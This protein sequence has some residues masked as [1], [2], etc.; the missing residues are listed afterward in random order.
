MYNLKDVANFSS[1]YTTRLYE[2]LQEFKETGWVLK[3]VPQLRDI[4]ATGSKFK[5]YKDL[6]K[7]T[8]A[9]A[10]QE[11]NSYYDM[12]LK[13]EELKEGRKVVAVKFVFKKAPFYKAV[14][15]KPKRLEINSALLRQDKE[16]AARAIQE[17]PNTIFSKLLKLL[18]FK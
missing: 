18:Q 11:I 12:N 10:C 3:S 2:L 16:E 6:K 7:Y 1:L 9:H 4:F 17:A 15:P 13:F 5:F 14:E 8:F